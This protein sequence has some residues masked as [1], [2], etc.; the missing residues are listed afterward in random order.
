[1]ERARIFGIKRLLNGLPANASGIEFRHVKMIAQEI[2]GTGAVG[3][4]RGDRET[5]E[6]RALVMEVAILRCVSRGLA[7]RMMKTGSD[8]T[9]LFTGANYFVDRSGTRGK[10]NVHSR[11][12]V[13]AGGFVTLLAEG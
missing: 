2:P 6:A 8:D 10:R 1:L 9:F 4:P 13:T 3:S 7:V 5:H 12:D 11:L